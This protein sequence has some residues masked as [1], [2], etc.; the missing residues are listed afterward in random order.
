MFLTDPASGLG[1]H[2]PNP[3]NPGE[4]WC[5]ALYGNVPPIAYLSIVDM[6]T[7][8]D[9]EMLTFK[10][11]DAKAMGQHLLIRTSRISTLEWERELAN[12]LKKAEA[13]CMQNSG[14]APWGCE[15]FE[16]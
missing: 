3:D 8:V 13:L 14:R 4:C 10:K 12:A 6:A 15:W 7:D 11:A 16:A 5:K 2:A 9:Q 1:Q